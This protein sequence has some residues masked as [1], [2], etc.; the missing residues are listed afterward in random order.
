VREIVTGSNFVRTSNRNPAISAEPC[1]VASAYA[2]GWGVSDDCQLGRVV[3]HSGGY[4]GYGSYVALLPDKG[5]G[6]FAFSNRT[7]GPVTVPVT[8]ALLELQRSLKLEPRPV[9]VSAGLA[10][11]YE[12]AKAVWRQGRIEAAPLGNNVLLDRDSAAWARLIADAKAVA[13]HCSTEASI[14]PISVMEGTFTWTCAKGRIEGRVQRT[15]LKRIEIQALSF[16]PA[17]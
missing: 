14:R 13:G 5:I 3:A 17:S 15:P 9:P 8:K 10:Q 11:V 2:M 12:A 7:Y 4:P 6:M 16:T 1:R